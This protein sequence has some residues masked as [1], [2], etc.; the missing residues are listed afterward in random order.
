MEASNS[1]V[2]KQRLLCI[3]NIACLDPRSDGDIL[4]VCGLEIPSHGSDAPKS[5]QSYRAMAMRWS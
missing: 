5:D 4:D 2:H 3:G 1:T